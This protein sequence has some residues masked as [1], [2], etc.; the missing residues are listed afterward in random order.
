VNGVIHDVDVEET[1][2]D[3]VVLRDILG[4]RVPKVWCGIETVR[5]CTVQYDGNRGSRLAAWLPS[6]VEGRLARSRGWDPRRAP[7]VQEAWI[8]LQVAQ[9]AA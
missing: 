2:A 7:C 4:I 9:N 1:F 8:D 6:D 5:A 3:A